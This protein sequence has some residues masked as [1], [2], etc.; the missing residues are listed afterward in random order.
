MV[1]NSLL[2]LCGAVCA[3]IPFSASADRGMVLTLSNQAGGNSILSFVRHGNGKLTP[4]RT[5]PTGG[6]G[7]GGGLGSQG[8]ISVSK[9][10][11]Y[12][13]VVNA[14]SN[15]IS[16]FRKDEDE[17]EFLDVKP[18]GGV[19]P[20]SVTQSGRFIYAL[21]AGDATHPGNIQEF[22]RFEGE[23]VLIPDGVANLSA[24]SVGPAQVSFTPDGEALV[25][26]EKGTNLI[27]TFELDWFD[28]PV[29]ANF[30]PSFEAVK[31]IRKD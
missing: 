5:Y 3:M 21:N 27:D 6:L 8:A 4:S 22:V 30:Q 1:K 13:V 10:G 28:R 17:L 31:A 24:P 20:I 19:K 2:M 23:L 26:T 15:S 12:V 16:L 29:S 9:D 25:V 11:N 7:S 14:G 18:S